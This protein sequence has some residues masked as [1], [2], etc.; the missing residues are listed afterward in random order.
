MRFW[1]LVFIAMLVTGCGYK[2]SSKI[3]ES[4]LGNLIYVEVTI[5]VEDPKNSV[6]IKDALKEVFI[7]RL[8]RNIVPIEDAETKVY[9][10]L[11]SV[12]FPAIMHKDGFSVAYR[13]NVT[14]NIKIVYSSGKQ[15]HISTTGSYDFFVKTNNVITDTERFDAIK[16][17]SFDALDEYVATL[18]MRGLQ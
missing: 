17:A 7:S 3:A 15:E 8:G 4:V 2:P 12:S 14:L 1:I 18:S 6:L 16:S 5:N 10:S 13:A 11:G 9:A